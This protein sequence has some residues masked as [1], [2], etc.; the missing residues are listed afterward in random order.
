MTIQ[1]FRPDAIVPDLVGR[2]AA[3]IF[4]E[5]CAPLAAATGVPSA[6]LVAALAEREALAST[7]VGNGVAIPH[8]TH[9]GLARIVACLGRS[10]GGV[11]FGAPDGAPVMLFV[12]LLRPVEVAG[13]HLKALARVSQLLGNEDVRAELLA[14]PTAEQMQAILDAHAR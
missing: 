2:D 8:G 7:A 3:A 14:A 12:A 4:A 13:A 9:P 6:E 5:L 11:P 10:R 1:P